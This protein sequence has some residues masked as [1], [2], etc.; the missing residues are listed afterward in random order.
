MELF[1][2][3]GMITHCD[4]YSCF[5]VAK[6]F[7][8]KKDGPLFLMLRLCDDCKESLV[9]SIINL[10]RDGLKKRIEEIEEMENEEK[11]KEKFDG[12]EYVCKHCGEVF[13][14]PGKLGAHIKIHKKEGDQD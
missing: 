2:N 12:K 5:N 13:S 7:V 6:W 9:D 1:D 11:R 4:G 14:S 3:G 8:G 10:D